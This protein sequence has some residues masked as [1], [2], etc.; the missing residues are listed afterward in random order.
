MQS[1]RQLGSFLLLFILL[2]L[3]FHRFIHNYFPIA[4][5]FIIMKRS[6]SELL[7]PVSEVKRERP[8]VEEE[9]TYVV[10]DVDHNPSPVQRSS[11]QLVNVDV[12]P[13]T[14]VDRT[15]LKNVGSF[16][17]GQTLGSSP[18][19]SIV[20]CLARI[21]NDPSDR[22]YVIKILTLPDDPSKETRDETQGKM[23]I[24]TEYSLL[25]MLENQEGV[26]QCHGL[27]K[28]VALEEIEVED[29]LGNPKLVYSGK[30]KATNIPCFGL[31]VST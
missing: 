12:T 5:N 31:S 6:R 3:F 25:S 2:F 20:Q 19:S 9:E 29:E 11:F 30:N 28:D 8:S 26:I 24:H 16:V 21:P 13:G 15:K 17:I 7:A 18:V 10:P 1:H 27:Y 22:F 23:L 14:P 4:H